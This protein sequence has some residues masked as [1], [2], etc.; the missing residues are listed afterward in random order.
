V[1]ILSQWPGFYVG[2]GSHITPPPPPRFL[3]ES[4]FDLIFVRF[5]RNDIHKTLVYKIKYNSLN[6]SGKEVTGLV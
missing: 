2:G 6:T 5:F 4:G 1:L 3:P